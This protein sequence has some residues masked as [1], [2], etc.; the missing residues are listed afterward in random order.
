[1]KNH[2]GRGV[3]CYLLALVALLAAPILARAQAQITTGVIQGTVLAETATVAARATVE[4]KNT[5]TNLTKTLTTDSD[6]RFVFLQLP[7]GR[8][9]LTVSKQGYATLAQ[10]NLSLTV[11]QA[12][13]L[14]L[15]LKVSSVQERVTITA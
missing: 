13:N 9:T 6:G 2:T 1:M 5:D 8:Y 7:S 15:N 12:I 4:V 3:C 14:N 11:G 10:E